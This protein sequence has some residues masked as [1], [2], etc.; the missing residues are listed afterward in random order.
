MNIPTATTPVG[1]SLTRLVGRKVQRAD[2][3]IGEIVKVQIGLAWVDFPGEP[4]LIP[5]RR[6]DL[7]ESKPNVERSDRRQ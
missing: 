7:K 4:M 6:R 2:Y 1:G 5:F 3:T